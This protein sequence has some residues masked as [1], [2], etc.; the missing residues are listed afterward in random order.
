MLPN[1]QNAGSAGKRTRRGVHRP[2]GPQYNIAVRVT[3]EHTYAWNAPAR[4][5]AVHVIEL[6]HTKVVWHTRK[7]PHA[8]RCFLTRPHRDWL[9]DDVWSLGTGQWDI[10]S[11]THT[12]LT[13]DWFRNWICVSPSAAEI[14]L[15]MS[16]AWGIKIEET[17]WR[18]WCWWLCAYVLKFQCDQWRIQRVAQQARAPL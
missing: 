6:L 8:T 9:C 13:L 11:C 16:R 14:S 12:N 1:A 2:N 18:L 17:L 15:Q 5:W 3:S 10:H 7:W 4:I